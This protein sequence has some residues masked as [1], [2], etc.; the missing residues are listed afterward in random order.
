MPIVHDTFRDLLGLVGLA[1]KTF[2]WA[3]LLTAVGYGLLMALFAYYMADDGS[4]LPGIIA[5]VLSLVVTTVFAIFVA[6]RLTIARTFYQAVK[7][8]GI[9]RKVFNSLF[10]IMLGITNEN[11]AGSSAMTQALHGVSRDELKSRLTAAGEQLLRSERI[12]SALP[13]LVRWLMRKIQAAII[14]TVVKVVIIQAALISDGPEI[15][16]IEI[17]DKLTN[18]IDD[19]IVGLI[20]RNAPRTIMSIGA[21]VTL[22]IWLMASGIHNVATWWATA[23]FSVTVP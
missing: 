12:E 17:R 1:L 20:Y 15:D 3:A 7:Q 11:P 5:V 13:S 23:D 21:A 16:L 10:D 14:W 22:G 9:G 18:V 4:I 8:F 2:A 19:Q 6:V